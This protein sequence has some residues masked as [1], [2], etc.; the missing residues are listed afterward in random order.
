MKIKGLDYLRFFGMFLVISYHFFPEAL[1]GG[2]LGVNILFVL[3]GFL[4][5]FHLID[6]LFTEGKISYKN[7]YFKRFIRIF[8]P[9]LL[10]VFLVTIFSGLLNKDYTVRYFDQFLAAISFNYNIFEILR[11]G[12]YEGQFVKSLF[13]HTWSLA[14]EVHFYLLWPFVLS[15]IFKKAKEKRAIKRRFSSI[16]I[17]SSFFI[18]LISYL[19]MVGLSLSN[20]VD[21]GFVYF[22]F[23][24]RIGSFALG[25]IL[26]SFVKRFS[27]R[28]IPYNKNTIACSMI[29][30]ALALIFSYD[31][32]TTYYFGFLLTDLI[33]AYLILVAYS[34]KNLMEDKIMAK[35]SNYS[36][37][38]YVFHWPVFVMISSKLDRNIALLLTIILT[39]ILVLFNYHIFEKVFVGKDIRSIRRP[40]KVFSFD[41]NSLL[42]QSSIAFM[43]IA[44]FTLAI[45]ISDASGDLNSLERQ[46]M[47]QSVNQ[48]IDKIILDKKS[49]EN[50]LNFQRDSDLAKAKK[51]LSLTLLADSVIL[52]NREHLANNIKNLYINAEGSRPLENGA[53]LIKE[54]DQSGNL[55]DIVVIALGTNARKEPIESLEA[56]VD[57]LSRGKRL[58]LVT[59]YD[60]RYEQ[61]HRVSKAMEEISKKYDFITLMPWEEE[62]IKHPEYYKGTDGVH[63]YGNFDAYDAYLKLL[64]KAI[65]Q[66]L[67][68]PAKGE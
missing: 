47:T 4:I 19:L 20:K 50:Q 53:D 59:C 13:M 33:T 26:A 38:I 57:S 40:E 10:M 31:S 52:G 29:I 51:E 63:F 62:G 42:I 6:E 32:N 44:S 56:I 67:L 9:I 2:F 27:F 49:L 46:I 34:N 22:S 54:I 17:Y 7:F 68:K 55:G 64:E 18:Y 28:Q 37:G 23:F 8:P 48:D 5:T 41:K 24:T 16:L 58:I 65:D 3:S 25:A 21:R 60:N 35:A 15:L 45:A 30:F 66:S 61:P 43:F 36:Y 39:A 14:I 12:S 11:G 1:P